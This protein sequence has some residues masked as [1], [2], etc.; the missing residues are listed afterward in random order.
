MKTQ[1]SVFPWAKIGQNDHSNPY[2]ES[3]TV[4]SDN[5]FPDGVNGLFP[6]SI[7]KMRQLLEV[8]NYNNNYILSMH[9]QMWPVGSWKWLRYLPSLNGN[10]SM[11]STKALWYN[12]FVWVT[13]ILKKPP[14][15]VHLIL[16]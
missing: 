3:T 10:V 5:T 6:D 2:I 7:T 8:N 9:P 1:I 4:L 16:F 13:E 11:Q 15:V 12:D 14:S